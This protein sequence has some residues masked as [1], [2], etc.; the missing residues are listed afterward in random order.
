MD[1][2]Q[3]GQYRAS[4]LRA[5][6]IDIAIGIYR[7]EFHGMPIEAIMISS[8]YMPPTATFLIRVSHTHHYLVSINTLTLEVYTDHLVRYKTTSC[9]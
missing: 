6:A 5:I 3:Y 2:A 8:S 4:S 7:K 9:T 1:D